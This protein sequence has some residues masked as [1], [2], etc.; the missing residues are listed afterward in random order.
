MLQER[1]ES[2]L[3]DFKTFS[4][5]LKVILYNREVRSAKTVARELVENWIYL[6][7]VEV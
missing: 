7:Y 3:Y 2:I 5:T 4:V 6:A 1:I